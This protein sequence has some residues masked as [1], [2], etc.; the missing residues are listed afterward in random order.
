MVQIDYGRLALAKEFYSDQGFTY[1]EVPWIVRP[2]SVDVT[3]PSD[4]RRF[5]TLDGALVGSGEQSFFDMRDSL[6][7]GKYQTITPCFRDEVV[8]EWNHRHFMKL[9]LIQVLEVA[10]KP[11][12]LDQSQWKT[13]YCVMVP[14]MMSVATAFF[15]MC[16]GLNSLTPHLATVVT[17]I[18]YDIELNGVEVGSYG[19]REHDGFRWIYGTGCAEP[20]LSQALAIMQ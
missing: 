6:K 10:R 16:S 8:T 5:D 14:Y 7:P 17:D 15:K 11:K 9:E 1:I 4:K 2:G 20:R 13:L 12:D 19:C 18:G 3:L